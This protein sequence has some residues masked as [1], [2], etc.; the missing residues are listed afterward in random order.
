[1]QSY[2]SDSGWFQTSESLATMKICSAIV[3]THN[4][5]E[6]QLANQSLVGGIMDGDTIFL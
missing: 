6:K 3:P 4:Y 2:N 1:M 5:W